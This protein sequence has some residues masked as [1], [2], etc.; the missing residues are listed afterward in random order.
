M[1]DKKQNTAIESRIRRI[2]REEIND[3]CASIDEDPLSHA[4]EIVE[5]LDTSVSH[6][7]SDIDI[8][9]VRKNISILKM[10]LP[11]ISEEMEII[12]DTMVGV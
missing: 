7:D 6:D 9:E 10:I 11:D 5:R 3:I 4:I 1:I 8:H 12:R 2:I